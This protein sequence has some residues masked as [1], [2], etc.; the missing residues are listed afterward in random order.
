MNFNKKLQ[1]I[2]FF[3][4]AL[5]VCIILTFGCTK[6]STDLKYEFNSETGTANPY[7]DISFAVISD[8][9]IYDTSLGSS[10]SAFEKV[11]SSDR[12]LLLNSIDLMD[13]ATKTIINSGVRFVLI[14]GDLTKDGELVNHQLMAKK[15]KQFSSRGIAV[16]VI[17]GN[18]DINN[19]GAERY[20]GD[21]TVSVPSINAE[22]FAKIY[23]DFGFNSALMRDDDSLS[24][25]VEP[26]NG[27][28][29]LC[30]D[31]CRYREN[32]PGKEEIVSGKIS[33][34]TADWIAGV[35]S[36]A[37]GQN[38]AVMV[39][40]HH[41]VVEHWK[42]QSKLHPDYLINGY[43]GFGE[44]LASWN[45]RVAFTGH[46]HA[47]D[48]VL[49]QFGDKRIY[50]IETGS[51]VTFPCPIR[52]VNIKDNAM[53]IRTEKIG[54]KIYPDPDFVPNASAFTKRTVVI[55]AVKTLKKY[56]ASDKD[57]EYMGQAVGDT[58]ISHYE[59]D[60]NPSLRP[61]IDESEFGL[62]GRFI[63]GQ[64]K[65]VFDG[66]WEDLPPADNDVSLEF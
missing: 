8:I 43:V 48:I 10:G 25:V 16:Y 66:L 37:T 1:A 36:T 24:Y 34:K 6:K 51:L 22:D 58:F 33:Q 18:H 55:E 62:W 65:Y 21:Q 61:H 46:Y 52:Y 2:S 42:G 32:T 26:V 49:A 40:I 29:L 14:S 27:L 20:E 13:Y 41:G 5:L 54:Y 56:R 31:S 30:I 12:K 15:L 39:M 17:P 11:M 59:G 50:D 45:A 53:Q 19:P 3:N 23:G 63:Y 28:W 4:V 64:Q 57:A 7:P 9:H 60:E 38:K 35:L 44:F 47:Q